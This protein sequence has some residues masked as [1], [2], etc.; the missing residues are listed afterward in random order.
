[1]SDVNEMPE[2]FEGDAPLLTVA[3]E[4]GGVLIDAHD[5]ADAVLQ[6]LVGAGHPVAHAEVGATGDLWWRSGPG[7]LDIC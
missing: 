7:E 5:Q 2:Q 1:M 6:V 4:R 3:V